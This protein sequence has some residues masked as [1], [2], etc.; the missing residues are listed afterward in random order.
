MNKFRFI[1]LFSAFFISAIFTFAQQDVEMEN[2]TITANQSAQQQ[3]ES[4]RNVISV[5]GEAIALLPVHSIDELLRY[6]PGIEVQQRGPQGS[7]SDITIRGGTFQQVLV[8]IDGV[9]L[10]DPLTGHFSNYIPINPSEIERI[11]ILKGAASAIYGS[12]AVGG[13]V[14]IITKTFTANKTY[15][16]NLIKG[17]IVTGEYGL[18]N[19]DAYFRW[20]EKKSTISGG[21]I[22][23]NA[24]GPALRGTNGFF[25]LTTA[26]IAF[27]QKLKNEWTVSF[28][29]AAD[30]RKF[31]AQNFYT[32]FAS[33]TSNEIVNSW[34]NQFNLNKKTRKGVLNFD[35]AYK[36]LRD[37]Y[38]FRPSSVPNDNRTNL[39]T[40]QLYYTSSF[41]KNT[42][43]TTGIQVHRKQITSNDRGNHTLWHGATY[44]I[45]RHK[46]KNDLYLNESLRLDWD[47]SYGAVIIPQINAAWSP[48]KFTVRA[49]AGKSI[50][51][52]DFTERYNNYNKTLVTSG[53]IGNPDLIAEDS[54]NFEAGA[55]YNFSSSFKISGTIF[56]RNHNNLIDWAN[57][58]YIDM[59]RKINLSPIGNY[60]LAKNVEKVKTSGMEL[61][62]MYNKRISESTNL[63]ATFGFTWINS[64]NKDSIPSLYISSHAKYLANFSM[65]YTV[66]SFL[67]SITGLYK[68]RNEQKSTA[69][70]AT[71]T[72]SY[73]ILNA[74]IGYQ[75]PKKFGRIFVQADNLFNKQYSDLLG[76]KMPGRWLSG[77]FEIAL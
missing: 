66:K 20:S 26:N 28:R 8:I 21:V 57:T 60:A 45:F 17:R 36:K 58:A 75:L 19:G 53:R 34:W 11:E 73:F 56:Y 65:A 42:S 51:D 74:K 38:W 29:T 22:T 41:N 49:S 46:F 10:N 77:G 6:L 23:N 1:F 12:E 37:Q 9:K 18:L 13:V 15:T 40:S 47:E 62:M 2:V 30:F 25:H 35:V 67:F 61:D 44:A 54:W 43:Y 70:N 16:K 32:T 14:H 69:I 64:E 31:N 50:R 72:P 24:N 52:A 71:L 4:G 39:F 48:S 55:D 63:L 68:N 59:P 76:S 7:Q 3:K 27:S 33:D 5:K